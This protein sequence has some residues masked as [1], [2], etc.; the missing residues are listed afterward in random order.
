MKKFSIEEIKNLPSDRIEFIIDEWDY[1]YDPFT[2]N[3]MINELKERKWEFQQRT[4]ERILQF[5]A[6]NGD[7]DFRKMNPHN[8][9]IVPAFVNVKK[10]KSA[11]TKLI[12]IAV[13][14]I[15]IGLINVIILTK[16]NITKEMIDGITALN[17]V[18]PI[19]LVSLFVSAG[20][21]LA[22]CDKE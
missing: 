14:G 19:I 3:S 20:I 13:L 12:I 8:V 2:I 4:N 17:I 1:G 10:I 18:G 16:H 22:N 7:K 9:P 15:F 21:N 5:Q 11:G 6:T